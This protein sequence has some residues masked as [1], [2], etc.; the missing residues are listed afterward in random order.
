VLVAGAFLV[1]SM[2]PGS[3]RATPHVF[4]NPEEITIPIF[5]PILTSGPAFKYPSDITV[6]G[7][8]GAIYD[9][10]V[11]LSNVYFA[12]PSDIDILLVGPG[13]QGVVLMDYGFDAKLL[14]IA[15]WPQIWVTF[16][17]EGPTGVLYLAEP[18][19][20]D[21][22]VFKPSFGSGYHGTSAPPGPY[23][24]TLDVFDGTSPNGVWSLYVFDLFDH[25][26]GQIS[27]GWSLSFEMRTAITSFSP[28][29]GHE[30]T[31]VTILGSDFAGATS[32]KFG[33]VAATFL[34]E[35][36]TKITATAPPGVA[37]GRISVTTPN[38]TGTSAT[39]FV[40]VGPSIASF[41]PGSGRVG[42]EVTLT[43]SGF[44][45]ATGVT[46]GGSPA[47]FLVDTDTRITATVPDGASTGR[48]AVT[49]SVGT[50]TSQTDFVIE[51]ART[52]KLKLG[53][54]ARGTVRV[55][56]GFD[57]CASQVPVKIQHLEHGAW[58]TVAKTNTSEAGSYSVARLAE[59]GRFRAVAPG[60]K[61]ES[62]DRCLKGISRIVTL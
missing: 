2:L 55:R 61:L 12:N 14:D 46:F 23:V 27:E 3:V 45:G 51:H 59:H 30:G 11:T 17:D 41:D 44:T 42:A 9:V 35:S 5:S 33:S 36:P 53:S 22:I 43:G 8:P 47:T 6:S 4:E 40:V 25:D 38:G 48:I 19:A 57:A 49:T 26:L 37:T 39:D 15:A 50:G 21:R 52:V 20:G 54:R 1:V 60:R 62:G 31:V 18:H 10:N 56:D 13:G 58:K 32:V 16:D 28:T 7:L 34:V 24:R 29:T